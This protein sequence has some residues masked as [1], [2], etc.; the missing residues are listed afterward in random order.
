M[1]KSIKGTQTEKHLLTSFAGE[2]Q[3]R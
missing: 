3:A 1:E 2:S